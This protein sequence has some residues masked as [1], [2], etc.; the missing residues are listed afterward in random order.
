MN[1]LKGEKLKVARGLILAGCSLRSVAKK[2]GIHHVTANILRK[3]MEIEFGGE[4]K[5]GC[6][7]PASHRGMCKFRSEMSESRM[8]YLKTKWPKIASLGRV[9]GKKRKT[10]KKLIQQIG[11]VLKEMV[12]EG[13]LVEVGPDETGEM[14]YQKVKDAEKYN[15]GHSVYLEML[16]SK[17]IKNNVGGPPIPVHGPYDKAAALKRN[18]DKLEAREKRRLDR[19]MA[20]EMSKE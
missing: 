3:K 13:E 9:K 10:D 12:E 19:E 18:Q 6:A 14:V 20:R 5:C 2:S 11:V 16:M 1:V 7:R 15:E 4:I 17:K 8:I